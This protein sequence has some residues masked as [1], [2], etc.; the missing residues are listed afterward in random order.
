MEAGSV[1]LG[2]GQ[3]VIGK[4]LKCVSA[5]FGSEPTRPSAAASV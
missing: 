2:Y 4:Y 3:E 1:G 5:L